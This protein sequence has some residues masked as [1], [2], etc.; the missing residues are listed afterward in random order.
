MRSNQ[1]RGKRARA[2][3][4]RTIAE[5]HFCGFEDA[6]DSSE[7]TAD[8]FEDTADSPTDDILNKLPDVVFEEAMAT[9]ERSNQNV[10]FDPVEFRDQTEEWLDEG[11]PVVW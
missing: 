6:A 9:Q 7:D 5:E 3:N 8:S 11:V 10:E 2:R 1:A 4:R